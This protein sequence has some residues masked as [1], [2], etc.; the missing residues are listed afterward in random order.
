MCVLIQI[1]ATSK[2]FQKMIGSLVKAG[3]QMT[4]ESVEGDNNDVRGGL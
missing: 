3:E 1:K 2:G 4:C